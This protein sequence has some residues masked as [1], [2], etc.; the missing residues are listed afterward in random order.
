MFSFVIIYSF[1]V[2]ERNV[3]SELS[4]WR[5]YEIRVSERTKDRRRNEAI[6]QEKFKRGILEMLSKMAIAVSTFTQ[7]HISKKVLHISKKKSYIFLK[8][9]LRNIFWFYFRTNVENIVDSKCTF[10]FCINS[11]IFTYFD[12]NERLFLFKKCSLNK[13]SFI[14]FIFVGRGGTKIEKEKFH[15]ANSDFQNE[16]WNLILKREISAKCI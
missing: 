16:I 6:F 4:A 9:V 8:K 10:M 15:R 7:L 14:S 1:Q 11:Y 13:Y 3:Y 2:F 5:I 12:K